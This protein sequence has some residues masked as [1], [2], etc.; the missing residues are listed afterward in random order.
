[1]IRWT[2]CVVIKIIVIIFLRWN[3]MT[4][5]IFGRKVHTT[6]IIT[7]RPTDYSELIRKGYIFYIVLVITIPI[8]HHYH[9]VV[10]ANPILIHITVKNFH[11]IVYYVVYDKLV[12]TVLRTT[13]C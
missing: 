5:N 3:I 13:S 12:Y 6:F 11:F 8:Y 7:Y 9:Y 1:V 2:C 4:Y 10:F